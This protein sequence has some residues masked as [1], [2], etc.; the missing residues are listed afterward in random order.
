[1]PGDYLLL[2]GNVSGSRDASLNH[3]PNFGLPVRYATAHATLLCEDSLPT[4]SLPDGSVLIGHLFNHDGTSFDTDTSL[5]LMRDPASVQQHIVSRCWG[6]YL[7]VQPGM[8]QKPALQL[9]RSASAAGNLPCVYSIADGSGFV[10]SDIALVERAGLYR[11][12]IDWTFIAHRLRYPDIKTQRTGLEGV[13]ELLPGCSLAIDGE[14][15]SVDT[16]WS[17][18]TFVAPEQR[19]HD[20]HEAAAAIRAAVTASVRAWAS[21]DTSILLELSGGLDS[22]IVA[23]CLC[24]SEADITCYN[25]VTPVPGVDERHYAALMAGQLAVPLHTE[26]LELDGARFD[27]D[28]AASAFTP[29]V[30]LLQFAIDQIME[31]AA[32]RHGT[33]TYYSGGGGDSVFCYLRTA[34]PAA[35]AFRAARATRG[36]KA[37]GDLAQLH[38]CTFWKAASLTLAKLSRPPRSACHEVTSF[39]SAS[40]PRPTPEPHPWFNAPANALPGDRE[41][42]FD[43][44]GNQLF[45]GQAPRGGARPMRFPL[46]AQPVMEACLRAPS[47]MWITDGRNRALA[48]DAFADCLPAEVLNRRS[49]ATYMSYLGAIY[50]RNRHQ[51]GEFLLSGRLHAH[52]LLDGPAITAFLSMPLAPRDQTFLRMFDLCMVENWVGQQT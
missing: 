33:A 28:V 1:M 35:D 38:Q 9:I 47:W 16:A 31:R 42:I 51:I 6:S 4:L 26:H 37:I 44:A 40:G 24:D 41:R 18:W 48:R 17:P 30:G 32:N 20:R 43:L 13:N 22:S 23:A 5:G 50:A 15:T 49:K 39:L 10:T 36:F 14:R 29:G 52:G 46:L 25:L 27:F 3:L 2:L 11:R 8:G 7:L 34:A 12:R 21:I 45:Q 19:F